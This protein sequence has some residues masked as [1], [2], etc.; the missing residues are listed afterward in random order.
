MGI[1]VAKNNAQKHLGL[2]LDKKSNFNHHIKE[3]LA[4][5]MKGINVIG[6]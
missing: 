6:N 5:S 3:K 4:K 2:F 1:S